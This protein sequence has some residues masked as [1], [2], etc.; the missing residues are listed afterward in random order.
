MPQV[1]GT[2][3]SAA[4]VTMPRV[5]VTEFVAP[6]DADAGRVFLGTITRKMVHR[7]LDPRG[8]AR[9]YSPLLRRTVGRRCAD[10]TQSLVGAGIVKRAPYSVGRSFGY[11]LTDRVL[12]LEPSRWRLV[13]P[14]VIDRVR[15]WNERCVEQQR[16]R[17]WPIDDRLESIQRR[18]LTILPEVDDAL[19]RLPAKT[20]LCQRI[21]VERL[22]SRRLPYSIS[23]TGRRFNALS[24][25]KREL[26]QYLRLAGEPLACVDITASQ[27]SLLPLAL[28]PQYPAVGWQGRT[29]YKYVPASPGLLRE[30]RWLRDLASR[31][32][33]YDR[34]ARLSRLPRDYVKHRFLVD[35]LAK[36]GDYPS[37]FEE[38]FRGEFPFLSE[39]IRTV[40]ARDH[41]ALIRW[42]QHVEARL[43]IELVAPKLGGPCANRYASRRDFLP[44]A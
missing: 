34:L 18:H 13:D 21:V 36:L 31:G 33:F 7:D 42:L 24:G 22:K 5:D 20:L 32:V 30:L 37:E 19:A 25:L 28:D 8:F 44:G 17:R 1:D 39:A 41:G 10:I 27:P 29:T 14:D 11:A 23:K 38:T 6:W 3:K 9:L 15:Q 40:N 2:A 35:V 26:R 4:G 16:E 43:V 12:A